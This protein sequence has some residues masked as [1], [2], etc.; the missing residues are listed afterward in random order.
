MTQEDTSRKASSPKDSS[1]NLLARSRRDFEQALERLDY[2]A[3][4]LV[5]T[6]MA[7]ELPKP[8][9]SLDILDAGCGTGLCGPRVRPYARRLVGVDLSSAMLDKARAAGAYDE[10]VDAELTAF[11]PTKAQPP[12]DSTTA[13]ARWLM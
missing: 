9:A 10:L 6:A 8:S 12:A 2:R 1:E 7:E 3:P 13:S 4:Q 11:M 5:S